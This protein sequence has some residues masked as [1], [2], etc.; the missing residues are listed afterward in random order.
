MKLESRKIV[1]PKVLVFLACL[2]PFAVLLF[3]AF[4]A[5]T[6][7]FTALGGDPGEA[8]V[9]RFGQWGIRLLLITLAISS[10]ARLANR[11][12][13]I[14][15][16]RM[17]G[18]FA[19]FY[20]AFHLVSYVG[21]LAG[22]DFSEV[23]ADFTKRPYIIAGG[24]AFLLLIPL[25]VTSTRAAQRRLR[26]NWARLH[27]LVYAALLLGVLHIAWLAKVSYVDA[28]I[29]G[30]LAFLLLSERVYQWIKRQGIKA[31]SAA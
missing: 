3:D 21:I 19:F 25:A 8:I 13:L 16:R 20:L 2:L 17:L 30:S 29:Y 1:W 15:Y 7:E 22:A 31:K 27:R 14:R 23:F 11:P 26:R 18:L 12:G 24:S 9:H 10:V 4:R 5:A 6:G 28:F